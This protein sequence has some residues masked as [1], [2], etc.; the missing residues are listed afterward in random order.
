[1][2]SWGEI[3]DGEE[4]QTLMRRVVTYVEPESCDGVQVSMCLVRL[5]L[6]GSLF[7]D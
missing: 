3:G 2:E 1:M 6:M 7:E 4:D 5:Y